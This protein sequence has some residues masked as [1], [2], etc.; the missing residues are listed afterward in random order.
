RRV[1]PACVILDGGGKEKRRIELLPGMTT[2][3]R[4]PTGRL[5]P[6]R[7]RWILLRM[8]GAG[9][10]HERR[11]LG[12]AYYGQTGKQPWARDHY[13]RYGTSPVVF[14]AHFPSAVLDYDGDGADDWLVCSENFYGVL[15]VKENKDLVGPVVLSNVLA[16]HWTAYTFPSVARLGGEGKPAAFHHA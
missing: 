14:L 8:S 2:L 10:G 5:G 9:P 13:G 16:G 1:R 15:S 3:D 6:G 11:Y 7:G 12:A 4:G